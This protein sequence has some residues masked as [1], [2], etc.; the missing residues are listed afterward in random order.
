MQH[1]SRSGYWDDNISYIDY[2]DDWSIISMP[3]K[4]YDEYI[5]KW[6]ISLDQIVSDFIQLWVAIYWPIFSYYLFDSRFLWSLSSTVSLASQEEYWCVDVFL[7]KCNSS[8]I[9]LID[10][11]TEDPTHCFFL[12][13]VWSEIVWVSNYS[14]DESTKIA[15]I[16]IIVDSKYRKRG[17]GKKLLN[18]TV[19]HILDC[20]Y[21]PQY[22][23]KNNNIWSIK[24]A[25][26]LWFKHYLSTATLMIF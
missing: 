3:K 6:E 23:V 7:S 17:I 22:R 11:K 10:M 4:Y 20:W 15:H 24:I 12:Y 26:S 18:D 14:L 13:K 16:W 1:D 8:D 21:I 25:E 2:I 9:D 5:L 19:I